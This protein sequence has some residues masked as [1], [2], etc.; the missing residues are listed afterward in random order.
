M[1]SVF[2]RARVTRSQQ[3]LRLR[4]AWLPLSF[5]RRGTVS[6]F[7]RVSFTHILAFF[8]LAVEAGAFF[9]VNVRLGVHP[10]KTVTPTRCRSSSSDSRRRRRGRGC[11]S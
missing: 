11:A 9:V 2:S 4:D 10:D 3:V 8:G 5:V 1:P 7:E 6:L